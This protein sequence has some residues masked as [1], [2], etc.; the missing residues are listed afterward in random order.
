MNPSSRKKSSYGEVPRVVC[1]APSN[2]HG[3]PETPGY[4]YAADEAPPYI[5][6]VELILPIPLI[7]QFKAEENARTLA[8]QIGRAHV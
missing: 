2:N 5:R 1:Y 7:D 8:E 3:N 6:K 4:L